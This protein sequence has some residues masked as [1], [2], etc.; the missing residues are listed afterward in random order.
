M[1]KNEGSLKTKKHVDIDLLYTSNVLDGSSLQ[2]ATST[3]SNACP[4]I[5]QMWFMGSQ[6]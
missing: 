4:E 2:S 3:F 1:Y 6:S 5:H